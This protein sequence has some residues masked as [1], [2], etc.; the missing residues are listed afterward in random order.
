MFKAHRE[1]HTTTWFHRISQEFEMSTKGWKRGLHWLEKLRE[2]EKTEG[3]GAAHRARAGEEHWVEV[4]GARPETV[5][6]GDQRGEGGR[7]RIREHRGRRRP[8][9]R[10]RAGGDFLKRDMGAPDS[11]QC[12]SGAHRTTHNSCPVNHRTTHRR[13]A[14]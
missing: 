13:K 1:T 2:R 10:S 11:L 12:L 14:F 5:D 6:S 9:A 7:Q 8:L 3:E 4:A